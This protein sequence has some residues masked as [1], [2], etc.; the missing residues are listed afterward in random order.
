MIRLHKNNLFCANTAL[1]YS[2]NP[3]TS[4]LHLKMLNKGTVIVSKYDTSP[5]SVKMIVK[6]LRSPLD[7]NH[8]VSG[9][10]AWGIFPDRQNGGYVFYTTGVDRINGVIETVGNT[11][12]ERLPL[13]SGFDKADALWRSLQKKMIDFINDPAHGGSAT[14]Y[15]GTPESILRPY[16]ENLKLYFE[17]TIDLTELRRRLGC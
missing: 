17:N 6:T 10:R 14:I 2:S 11:W 3:L 13:Q 15:S 1:W 12:A 9:N 5:D 16:W 7:V 8:P 4:M